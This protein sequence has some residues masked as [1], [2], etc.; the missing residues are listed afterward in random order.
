MSNLVR[1]DSVISVT[2]PNGSNYKTWSIEIRLL[3]EQHHVWKIVGDNRPAAPTD[4]ASTK[5]LEW[6][7]NEET[8]RPTI[9]LSLEHRLQMKYAPEMD[10]SASIWK[11][12]RDGHKSKVS[13]NVWGIC[14]R[15]VSVT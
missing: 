15:H 14:I 13:S 6:E 9:F 4:P 5:Y 3:L 11:K 12:L 2:K 10:N 7:R 1:A 8:A